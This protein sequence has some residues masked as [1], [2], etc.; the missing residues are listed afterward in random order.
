VSVARDL[1]MS[2]RGAQKAE[3]LASQ[4]SATAGEPSTQACEGLT[5]RISLVRLVVGVKT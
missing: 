4:L 3:T 2:G 5:E 1:R